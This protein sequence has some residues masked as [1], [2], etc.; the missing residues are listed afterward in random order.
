M[1]KYEK[2]AKVGEYIK[3]Y[4][5]KPCPDRQNTKKLPLVSQHMKLNLC[6][7]QRVIKEM[8]LVSYHLKQQMT[9]KA[10]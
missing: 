5:F 6:T 10:E 2:T 8:K 4:N 9:T 1:F 3:A 7:E